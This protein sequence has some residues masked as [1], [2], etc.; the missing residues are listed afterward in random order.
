MRIRP[1]R[2]TAAAAAGIAGLALVAVAGVAAASSR[3]PAGTAHAAVKAGAEPAEPAASAPAATAVALPGSA[4]AVRA[5][6][7]RVPTDWP[8]WSALG[9]LDLERGRATG[10]PTAYAAAEA[11]FA[12]SLQLHPQDNDAALA[13]Q[14]ALADSRHRFADGERLARA[15]LAVN[16]TS[17]Q[18]L[19][20][21]TDALTEQG[22]YPEA[23]AAAEQLDAV[24]PGVASFTRLSYQAELRGRIPAAVELM[25]RAAGEATTPAQVAFARAMEGLLR[26]GTGDV[27]AAAT[28]WRA[29]VAVAPQDAGL[30]RLGARLAWAQGDHE[31]AARRYADLMARRP[32]A[33]DAAAQAEVLTVL[34]RSRE[35]ATALDVARAARTLAAGAGIEPEAGDV[36]LEADHGDP[37]RAVELARALWDRSPSV[38][39]ADAYAWALHAAHRDA[40]ALPFADRALALGGR[41]APVLAHRGTI[42]AALGDRSGAVADLRA[43]LATDPAFSPAQ[44]PRAQ[45]L[46]DSLGVTR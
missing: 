24:R 42:R 18:A 16:P 43:A 33:A 29:G 38:G 40:E 6:V 41:P 21:L 11:D 32:S 10:D 17:P 9:G 35:A 31:L 23:Q 5:Q 27:A 30:A 1:P 14:A 4:E 25:A 12:R 34:G 15:A 39:A 46:L 3:T 22:R 26:L 2:W 45:A 19:A 8:A 7:A 37:A 36:L 28:A 13:G 20:W 44:A